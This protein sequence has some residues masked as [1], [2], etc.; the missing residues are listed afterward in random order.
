MYESDEEVPIGI[1]YD[2]L[3]DDAA[4]FYERDLEKM[5]DAF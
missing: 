2:E 3:A 1:A 5:Y 4:D